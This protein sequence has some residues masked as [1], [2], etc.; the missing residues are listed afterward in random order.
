MKICA[1]QIALSNFALAQQ[2][3][4]EPVRPQGSIFTRPYR[5]AQIPDIRPGNSSRL[6]SLIRGGTLYLSAQDAIALALDNNIDVELARYQAPLLEWRQERAEAGGALPGIQSGANL[7]SSTTSG[8]GVLGSQQAAGVGGGG[9]GGGTRTS[10]NATVSQIGPVTQNLDPIFQ[11]ANAFSHR[12][13]PLANTSQSATPILVQ[14]SRNFSGSLQQG[15]ITGGSVSVSYRDSY[16]NENAPTD[17]LNP[18]VAH[19]LNFSIQHPL[20]QGF[21]AAVNSRNIT[22]SRRNVRM[23]E[24]NFRLTLIRTVDTVLNSYW[25]LVGDYEDLKAKRSA[26]E[27][28]EKFL[29]ENRRREELG[30]LAHLDVIS[31]ESQ[32]ATSQQAVVTSNVTLQQDEA[33]LR[34]LISRTGG[35]DVLLKGVSIMPTD[36]IVVPESET[37]PPVRELLGRALAGRPDLELDKDNIENSRISALGSTSQI[38][39]AV[40][41][42]AAQSQSGLAGSP[43]IV[44]GQAPDPYFVGGTGTAMAQVFRRNFPSENV[45]V[46]ARAL[47]HNR[48]AQADLGIDRLQLA[49]Q[50]LS[51]V[52]N[53]NQVQVDVMNAIISVQQ[54]TGRY[55]TALQNRIL[56]EKLLDAEQKKFQAGESTSFNVIQ[57]QRDLSTAQAQETAALVGYQQAHIGLDQAVGSTLETY[58]IVVSEHK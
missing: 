16:L 58:K 19:T 43:R 5:A 49:Q 13:V 40:T 47:I 15:L 4:I 45:G 6:A 23:N 7:A 3:F 26:L 54:A 25:S 9:S 22:I 55:Q 44:Q 41:A 29:A 37:I 2:Q 17:L 24:P 46:Q 18:S 53:R 28:A 42:F 33:T 14:N 12:T 34:S 36:R 56:E 1:M 10:G 32:V 57:Q 39:P 51:A 30:V 38:L 31:A 50:E 52:R 35:N 20:A 21:G 8:Q 11:E 48:Q 27:T